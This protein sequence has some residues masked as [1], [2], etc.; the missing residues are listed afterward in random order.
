MDSKTFKE[1]LK[2]KKRIAKL[3]LR[4]VLHLDLDNEA[5]EERLAADLVNLRQ[6]EMDETE[7]NSTEMDT[8]LEAV[9]SG[10]NG[11][12]KYLPA[13]TL[14]IAYLV[15]GSRSFANAARIAIIVCLALN[16]SDV[17]FFINKKV[18]KLGVT[19]AQ[20]ISETVE[21]S[22][23]SE[24]EAQAEEEEQAE[25]EDEAPPPA[26]KKAAEGKVK[27]KAAPAASAASAAS[28]GSEKTSKRA[29]AEELLGR[30]RNLLSD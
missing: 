2:S 14:E 26:K 5:H 10:D 16:K 27:A 25:E 8:L 22:V 1:L 17:S 20:K 18:A 23:E 6:P 4:C 21:D 7:L 29:E 28:G 24:A 13:Q 30:I 9:E 11:L 19:H 3:A 15:Y 12:R